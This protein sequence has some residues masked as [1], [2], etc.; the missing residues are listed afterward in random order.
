M[1]NITN[2]PGGDTPIPASKARFAADARRADSPQAEI[3]RNALRRVLKERQISAAELARR[4]QMPTPNVIYNHLRGDSASL[5]QVA[6]ENILAAFPDA[7]L[8]DITGIRGSG[9][10]AMPSAAAAAAAA[11]ASPA[12]AFLVPV[13]AETGATATDQSATAEP[14]MQV[15]VPAGTLPPG[16][17][18]FAIRVAAAGAERLFAL[19]SL[20]VC[21]RLRDDVEDLPDGTLVIL[22]ARR[23]GNTRVDVREAEHVNGRLWL[24][25]RSTHPDLQQPLPGPT[26]L[27]APTR[28]S[29]G[30]TITILGVVVASWQ[31]E[32]PKDPI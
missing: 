9:S 13:V 8:A 19:G 1:T 22:R 27:T 4:A 23:D 24:W 3:R 25:R 12:R 16:P 11:A 31:P 18:L 26:P 15:P 6:I 7:T 10:A 29:G 20:L 21:Q 30:E 14:P 2:Q 5:S 17:D 32:A 28:V